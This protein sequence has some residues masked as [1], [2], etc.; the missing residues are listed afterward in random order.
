MADAHDP[1]GGSSDHDTSG[2]QGPQ[3]GVAVNEGLSTISSRRARSPDGAVDLAGP[4]TLRRRLTPPA[5]DAP[6][7]PAAGFAESLAVIIPPSSIDPASPSSL[8]PTEFDYMD[9]E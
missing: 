4:P 7:I 3:G 1:D 2:P 5:A 6:E 8:D 9:G